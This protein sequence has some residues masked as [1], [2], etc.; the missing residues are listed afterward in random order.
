M[1]CINMR[2]YLFA[3][4]LLLIQLLPIG[5][6]S[7]QSDIK[8]GVLVSLSG[9]WEEIG[10]NIRQGITL[11]LED[12]KAEGGRH[13]IV[14]DYQDTDEEKSGAKVVS[15]YHYLR[16]RGVEYFVG[17]TGV[18]GILA[19]TPI[20]KED[21]I[22]L[23]AP[24]STNSFYLQSKK[25]FNAG[26]DNA[27]T[28][29]AIANKMFSDGNRKVA[30]F[31]SQQPWET[32][33]ARI[34]DEEFKRLGGEILSQVSPA[35][36]QIDLKIEALKILKSKPEAIFMSNFNQIA[37]ASIALT[38]FKFS[39]RKYAALMDSSHAIASK[40]TLDGTEFYLFNPPSLAFKDK[41]TKKF[42]NPPGVFAD[43]AF[44]GALG[45]FKALDK[46]D[47]PTPE[48]TIKNLRSIKINGSGGKEAYF[49]EDG[50]MVR[51]ISLCAVRLGKIECSTN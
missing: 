28:T 8:I 7:A 35:A 11:A 36:D 46:E 33:Q 19:L 47:K 12:Y 9:N 6:S 51:D 16:S 39:G 45:L 17:P 15:G 10:N 1:E 4:L 20:A 5:N 3:F 27:I 2:N 30:I 38:N 37:H 24:T 21:P 26:G 49:N 34:F 13:N 32:D 31:S 44:D 41:F 43:T 18:P 22:L 48:E 50:L 25:F 14:I 29:K 40:G 23:L 42:S